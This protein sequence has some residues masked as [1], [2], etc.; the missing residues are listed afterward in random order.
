[1]K[2]GCPKEIKPQEFR[3]GMTPNAVREAVNR[4]HSVM[5]ETQAGVGA[6]FTDADYVAAG[7]VIAATAEDV[8]AGAEMIVKV[9]EPLPV[10]RKKLRQGQVLFTYLHLAA[11]PEQ[12]TELMASGVIA[13]AYETVTSPHGGL[14]LLSPMSEVAGRM[15]IQAGAHSLE[16]AQGGNGTLLGGVPRTGELAPPPAVASALDPLV[17]APL[18]R[19]LLAHEAHVARALVRRQRELRQHGRRSRLATLHL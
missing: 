17:A 6:G 1:M 16:K 12:T 9:K 18:E 3:V 13:I 4:G 5:V 10:E 8:F 14:P 2:I 19:H 7:A 11:D 15:A